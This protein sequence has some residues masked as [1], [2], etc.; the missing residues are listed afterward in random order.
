MTTRPTDDQVVVLPATCSQTA[1]HAA[2]SRSRA[3]LLTRPRRDT[4]AGAALQ[5]PPTFDP[6]RRVLHS[7]C[8][9]LESSFTSETVGTSGKRRRDGAPES[10]SAIVCDATTPAG[11]WYCSWIAQQAELIDALVAA[12]PC[13]RPPCL[14]DDQLVR[15]ER[16]IWFFVGQNASADAHLPG[17]P[18]HTD[19]VDHFTWHYQL[20]GAKVW[21]LRETDEWAQ[22]RPG[23]PVEPSTTVV[24]CEAGDVLVLSTRDW[25]HSTTLPPL[26]DAG[27]SGNLSVS[28]AREFSLRAAADRRADAREAGASSAEAGGTSFTNVDGL[29]A[30]QAIA[31]GSLVMTEDDP[32]AGDDFSLP[33][34]AD[35]NVEV[36]EDSESGLLCLV[37]LRDIRSGEFFAMAAD[38]E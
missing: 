18:E 33:T 1:F 27:R 13:A 15:Q 11:S 25:W 38:D 17:R 32:R 2:W 3:V 30:T 8:D 35:P 36:V 6:V 14:A 23:K 4:R 34:G 29:F 10:A 19:A 28:Y 22:R 21:R 16:P 24:R 9:A 5:P 7:H 26:D 12:V 31:A 37:A 20:C